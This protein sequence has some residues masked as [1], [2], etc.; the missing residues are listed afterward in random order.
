VDLDEEDQEAPIRAEKALSRLTALGLLEQGESGSV[1]MHRLVAE[2]A[3][4]SADGEAARAAVEEKLYLEANRL[5][6]AGYPAPLVAWQPHL[7][8][9][10]EEAQ[11][12][13]D[14]R[15][16]RL[17]NELGGHLG[18]TGDFSGALPYIER[19]LEVW[20]AVLGPEHPSTA[21][22]LNHLGFL[23]QGQGDLAGA[24]PH[25]ERALAI[26]EKVLGAEHPDTALSLNNLGF[27]LRS[28]GD[29]AG[30]HSY[31]E[32]ALAINE[33]VLGAEHP[34]TARRLNN[35]GFL[36][37]GEGDLAGARRYF[38]RALAIKEARL[39]PEHPDTKLVRR[40]LEVLGPPAGEETPS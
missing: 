25:Y 5:N 2:L 16:A 27:L 11:Q 12:R 31:Y 9:V 32:R 6:K 4:N 26:N 38:E 33:K 29:V 37:H 13:E 40:N 1:L 24:R 19:A 10:V 30:A 36:L 22:G 7:R 20:V 23:L 34:H 14:E 15:A 28:Q 17:C 8:A 18:M 21:T 39:G 3:R 35:L